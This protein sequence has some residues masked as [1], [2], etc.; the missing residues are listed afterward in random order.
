[1]RSHGR[2]RNPFWRCAIGRLC[3]LGLC[4]L[5]QSLLW[6][7]SHPQTGSMCRDSICAF[8]RNASNI[9]RSGFQKNGQQYYDIDLRQGKQEGFG[10]WLLNRLAINTYVSFYIWYYLITMI[11]IFGSGTSWGR[12]GRAARKG[13]G[14][15][16]PETQGTISRNNEKRRFLTQSCWTHFL[17]VDSKRSH[18]VKRVNWFNCLRNCF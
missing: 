3:R 1:M 9:S 5:P 17:F 4:R 7:G 2:L 6:F 18:E 10:G 16:Q 14:L 13:Q 8:K 15:I 12:W 11:S